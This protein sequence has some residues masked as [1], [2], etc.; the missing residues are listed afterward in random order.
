YRLLAAHIRNG[1]LWTS[2]N[3]A[4]NNTGA[5]GGTSSRNAVRWYELQGIA[6][7][8]TP[9][10]V[11]SGTLFQSSASNTTDQRHYWM[12]SVMVS[13]QGHAAMGFSVAGIN[14]HINAGTAG[15]LA[16]D[17]LGT[18]RTPTLYTASSTAYNPPSDP[19]SAQGRRWGD[20]S[21]TSLDPND[22]MTM[23]TVQEFCNATDS[24]GLQV[25]KLLAP[26]PARPTNCNPASVAAGSSNVL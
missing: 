3:I 5:T 25:A 14:E 17:A 15:R 12:G 10:V 19:G 13:G 1:R 18:M 4:V 24:Y 26:P 20:Y 9:A 22:D 8:Q 23:W 21:Y 16:S 2:Q 7:G 6:S 11:Q